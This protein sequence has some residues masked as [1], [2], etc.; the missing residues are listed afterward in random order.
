MERKANPDTFTWFNDR[1]DLQ[2]DPCTGI[3]KMFGISEIAK[4]RIEIIIGLF[5]MLYN[6]QYIL[7]A[8]PH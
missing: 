4:F 7:T 6:A 3:F 2:G 1:S 8:D 5:E